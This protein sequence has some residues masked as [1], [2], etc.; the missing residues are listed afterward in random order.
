MTRESSSADLTS[1]A[2]RQHLLR[3]TESDGSQRQE[4]IIHVMKIQ[5]CQIL[6]VF[7]L[8][9]PPAGYLSRD[10][11]ST[12]DSLARKHLPFWVGAHGFVRAEES[13]QIQ[14]IFSLDKALRDE[15]KIMSEAQPLVNGSDAEHFRRL[16]A[17]QP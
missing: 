7:R 3:S 9:L 15:K 17:Y 11:T 6:D 12:F 2:P 16:K 14:P 4:N 5:T 8:L 10:D 13:P 1:I